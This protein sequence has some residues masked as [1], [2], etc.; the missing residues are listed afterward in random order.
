MSQTNSSA[1]QAESWTLVRQPDEPLLDK[2]QNSS[3]ALQAGSWTLIRHAI[4]RL[5]DMSPKFSL[6]VRAESWTLI[7]PPVSSHSLLDM[8]PTFCWALR[9][10]LDI[11]Q[12]A[13]QAA[14]G[15]EFKFCFGPADRKLDIN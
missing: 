13:S 4:K 3:S 10:K 12:A 7:R 8:S 15:H 11:I 5:L 6:A 9:R 14:A 1:L 2:S